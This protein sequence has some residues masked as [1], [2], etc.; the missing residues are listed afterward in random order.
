MPREPDAIVA[1]LPHTPLR[2]I[3]AHHLQYI[4]LALAGGQ[5]QVRVALVELTEE[6]LH[7]SMSTSHNKSD[8]NKSTSKPRTNTGT[9][10]P[11]H[12]AITR[13]NS[14]QRTLVMAHDPQRNTGKTHAVRAWRYAVRKLSRPFPSRWRGNIPS[15]RAPERNFQCARLPSLASCQHLRTRGP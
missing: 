10:Y 6:I 11:C 1:I 5:H 15:A 3:I 12:T 13:H 7:T 4:P 9:R 14:I 8:T 2:R